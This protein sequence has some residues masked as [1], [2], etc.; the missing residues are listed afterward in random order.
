MS[1]PYLDTGLVLKLVVDEPLSG[2]VLAWLQSRN[3]PIPYTRLVEMEVENTLCAKLFRKEFTA[4][5]FKK[6]RGIVQDLLMDGMFFRP[7]L[8]LDEVILESLEAMSVATVKTGCRTLDLLHVV[9][10]SMLG[11][12]E[13]VTSDK[14]QAA[15]AK[16]YGL[17]VI[18][19]GGG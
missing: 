7:K 2:A 12:S 5:D 19:L 14:R 16:T 9:S 4:Q 17:K 10:A 18:L 11:C 1:Q 3:V 15:A 6:A 13:F 8:S